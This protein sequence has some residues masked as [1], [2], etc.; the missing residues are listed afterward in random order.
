MD[1]DYL[2]IAIFFIILLLMIY[3]FS[4]SS[5][6]ENKENFDPLYP[7]GLSC[8]DVYSIDKKSGFVNNNQVKPLPFPHNNVSD[9]TSSR[10]ANSNVPDICKPYLPDN[11]SN[12][13]GSQP[14]QSGSNANIQPHNSCP[15]TGQLKCVPHHGGARPIDKLNDL[16]NKLQGAQ[17]LQE[18]LQVEIEELQQTNPDSTPT[19]P[20]AD[21][22]QPGPCNYIRQKI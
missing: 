13:P 11:A 22:C 7:L 16:K 12:T 17:I 21:G 3:F 6:I 14:G 5:H 2:T 8:S 20:N 9:S 15:C 19:L 10:P 4:K 1:P 18:N